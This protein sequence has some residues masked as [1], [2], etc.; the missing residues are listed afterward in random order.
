M[1]KKTSIFQ[2]HLFLISLAVLILNDTFLKHQFGNFLTGKLSE[3]RKHI[4]NSVMP[5]KGVLKQ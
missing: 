1:N 3:F 2:T 4:E 5:K